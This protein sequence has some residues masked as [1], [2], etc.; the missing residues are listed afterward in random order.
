MCSIAAVRSS[1][2]LIESVKDNHSVLKSSSRA[3]E[4]FDQNSRWFVTLPLDL[5]TSKLAW[6]SFRV[7]FSFNRLSTS[8]VNESPSQDRW[9]SRVSTELQAAG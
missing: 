5:S 6:S 7:T 3:N 1:T 4:Q 8:S 9:T 2:V